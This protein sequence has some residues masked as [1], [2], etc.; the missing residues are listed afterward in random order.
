MHVHMCLH[1]YIDTMYLKI[2]SCMNTGL[3]AGDS[4]YLSLEKCIVSLRDKHFEHLQYMVPIGSP[5]DVLSIYVGYVLSIC[6]FLL[7]F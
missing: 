5:W 7:I 3:I 2:I 1:I 4:P 6:F